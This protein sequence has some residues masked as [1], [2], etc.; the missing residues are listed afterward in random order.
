MAVAL[1]PWVRCYVLAACCVSMWLAAI[2]PSG[3]LWK[4]V[5]LILGLT[6]SVQLIRESKELIFSEAMAL[7]REAMQQE[8]DKTSLALETYQQEQELQQMYLGDTSEPEVKEELIRAL[9]AL[10]QEPAAPHPA[11]TS[12]SEKSLYLAVKALLTAGKSETFI[13]EEVLKLRGRRWDEGKQRLEDLLQQGIENEW[14]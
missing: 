6:C 1:N 7:A 4:G 5:S 13:I 10:V 3:K 2:A 14:D 8:L 12:A 11:E 9:D